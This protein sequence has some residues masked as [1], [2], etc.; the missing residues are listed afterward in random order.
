M[1]RMNRKFTFYLEI[2]TF[3]NMSCPFCPSFTNKI[4]KNMDYESVVKAINKIKK[5]IG[6]LYFHVLGEP[7]LHPNFSNIIE[8]CENENIPFAVTT[9]GTLLNNN[10]ECLLNKQNISKINVSLQS[11]I[12]Y[13]QD[14]LDNY[15]KNLKEFLDY[16]KSIN[17]IIPINLRLWNDKNNPNILL[18]NNYLEEFFNPYIESNKNIRFS[19]ADEFEWPSSDS[20]TNNELTNCLGGKKQLAILHDGTV[21]LCCLDHQGKTKIGNIFEDEFEDILESDLYKKVIDGFNNRKP[22]FQLCK[23]CTFRNRFK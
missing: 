3:C 6:L 4:N 9:N 7:L 19:E 22:L 5:H 18:L 17:S 23:K 13:S 16:R 15:L 8:Y 11:L 12:Q 20:E 1:E 10:K 14:K 21:S 2:T